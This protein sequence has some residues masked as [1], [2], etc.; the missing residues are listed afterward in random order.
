MF[1]DLV[2]IDSGAVSFGSVNPGA[3]RSHLCEIAR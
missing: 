3:R 2:L 1:P